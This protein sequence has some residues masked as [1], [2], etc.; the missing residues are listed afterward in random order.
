VY[1]TIRRIHL[2]TGVGL[3]AFVVMYFVTGYVLIHHDWFP[4]AEPV[5]STREETLTPAPG[6]SPEEYAVLLQRQCGLAGKRQPPVRMKDGGWKFAYARPGLA[7]EVV[8][9]PSG[10]RVRITTSQSSTRETLVHFHRLH[11]YGGGRLYDLWM[12]LYDLASASM[13]VF[14]LSGIYLWY[15]L[16]KRRLLGWTLLAASF[17]FA[18]GTVLYLV[19]AR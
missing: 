11:G 7:H 17:A 6:L 3:L 5:K 9:P 16:T 2:Y 8:V 4:G 18:T 1:D 14:A 12:V 13:I 10:D 19:H 15:K